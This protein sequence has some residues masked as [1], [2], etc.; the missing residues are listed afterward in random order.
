[1]FPTFDEINQ[2]LSMHHDGASYWVSLFIA[3][4]LGIFRFRKEHYTAEYDKLVSKVNKYDEAC[5]TCQQQLEDSEAK[6]SKMRDHVHELEADIDTLNVVG[7]KLADK[8]NIVWDK[9]VKEH[10]NGR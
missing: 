8:L 1:M 3:T 4:M 2:I 9:E 5:R 6:C 7:R 10:N